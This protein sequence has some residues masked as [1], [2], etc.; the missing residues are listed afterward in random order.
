MRDIPVFIESI[1]NICGSEEKIKEAMKYKGPYY[2]PGSQIDFSKLKSCFANA[3]HM[4]Q[5]LIP[6][7]GNSLSD[8]PV[9]SHLKYMTDNPHIHGNHDG[10]VFHWC[11]K[12]M[13]EFIP[14]LVNQGKNPRIMLDYSGCLLHGVIDM[15][16]ND[17]IENLKL[18]TTDPRYSR[19]VEWLGTGWG[20]PVAPSTPVQD[21]RLH[22]EAWQHHFAAIFGFKALSRVRGFSPPEMALPNHPDVAYEFVKTLND[23]GYKWVMVQEHSVEQISDGGGIRQPHLPHKLL[24]KSSDGKSAEIIAIIKTQGSD[25]KLVAQMQPRSEARGLQPV[26]IGRKK[27]PPIV[28]QIA[29][30]ENGG[31]MM[32]EFPD[33][34]KQ[35]MSE[36]SHSETAPVNVSEYLEYLESKGITIK[37]FEEIQPLN[38]NRI[39]EIAKPGAGKKAIKKVIDDLR[40]K[41][42]R[43][44]MDGGS[45]T[46]NL[47]WI[48]GYD[49]VLAPMEEAS[50]LFAKNI[51]RKKHNKSEHKYRNAL[52]HLLSSQT[53]CYR[54]WG[55]GRWTD[56]GRELSNR[57]INIIKH[58][59]KNE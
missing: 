13:G 51:L 32:N 7:G 30:G 23:C 36:S 35:T 11:Y 55:E 42:D 59:F 15:G 57:T 27:I 33:Q 1:P 31:V 46:N 34:F 25:T 54:Y 19:C 43:F 50:A 2:L 22:V 20:H 16:F 12:R 53:S 49:H 3:L 56:Y 29:D 26:K 48:K 10:P 24:V 28:T 37:D 5:P 52:F 8:S 38:Q 21:F 4:H 6:E 41:D 47:S 45:W 44:H 18:I 9:I 58:D 17:V 39:W 14:E 40:K